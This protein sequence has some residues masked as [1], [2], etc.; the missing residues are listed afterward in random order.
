MIDTHCHIDLYPNPLAIA[1]RV[2]KAKI[3]TLAMTNLP[4]HFEAAIPHLKSFRY[5]R[6]ALG[7]H[8]LYAERHESEYVL[9][10]KYIDQTSYIGEVG[11]DFSKDGIG[12]KEIQLRSFSHVLRKIRGRKKILSLH[13]RRAEGQVLDM[14]LS[15]EIK[16]AIFHWYTGGFDVLDRAISHGYFFSLNTAMLTSKSG[17]AI[18]NRIPLSLLLTESDGPY[19]KFKNRNAE[20]AD[21]QSVVTF[22]ANIHAVSPETV[23]AQIEDNFMRIINTIR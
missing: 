13:S 23:S 15:Q 19:I 11:L 14:L 3:S 8:P 6:L 18:I 5:I 10:D 16:S 12:T 17:N 4:S 2:E 20:P 7:M 22:L 21:A 9:F 1:K